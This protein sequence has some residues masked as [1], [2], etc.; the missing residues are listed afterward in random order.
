ME[1][2]PDFDRSPLTHGLESERRC[3]QNTGATCAGEGR[4]AL[5]GGSPRVFAL[6]REFD[7]GGEDEAATIAE[8]VAYGLTLPDGTAATVSPTGHGFGRW[9]SAHSAASRL[10]SSLVWFGDEE[11]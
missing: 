4:H 7:E 11:A 6:V 9:R 10:R 5:N 8:V 3:T 2:R 1:H